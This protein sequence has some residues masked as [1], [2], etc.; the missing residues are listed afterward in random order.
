MSCVYN[1]NN[2]DAGADFMIC[3]NNQ[4]LHN[5]EVNP[6]NTFDC[7]SLFRFY[8][9]TENKCIENENKNTLNKNYDKFQ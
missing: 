3:F 1:N 7:C 2:D 5:N 9:K 4:Y 6:I 8:I